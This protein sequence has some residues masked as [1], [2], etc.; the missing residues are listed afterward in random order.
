MEKA[1]FP[2]YIN[3]IAAIVGI[4]TILFQVFPPQTP[5]DQQR[6]L[7]YFFIVLII[8]S[9]TF[10]FNLLSAKT[11]EYISIIH[12]H[13]KQLHALEESMATERK[14]HE[15]DKRLAVLEKFVVQKRGE[16]EFNPIWLLVILLL[17]AFFFYLR[18]LGIL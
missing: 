18:S 12:L 5:A 9:M 16:M 8:A 13:N 1:K 4:F 2:H 11:K 7:M 14:F 17:V 6:S 3:I 10:L 15:L